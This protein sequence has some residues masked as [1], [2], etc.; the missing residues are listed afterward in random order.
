MTRRES[1]YGNLER[2]WAWRTTAERLERA[3]AQ[4]QRIGASKTQF[5]EMAVDGLIER[6]EEQE[7]KGQIIDAVHPVSGEWERAEVLTWP[8]RKNKR[9][10]KDGEFVVRVR[11]VRDGY[12]VAQ[13]MTYISK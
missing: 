5:L 12:T 4:R 2:G 1:R 8:P 3:E 13:P 6:L 9:M 7:M 10:N 11:F